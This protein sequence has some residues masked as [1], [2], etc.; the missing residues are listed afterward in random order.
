M[1]EFNRARYRNHGSKSLPGEHTSSTGSVLNVQDGIYRAGEFCQDVIGDHFA[2]YIGFGTKVEKDHDFDH[3]FRSWRYVSGVDDVGV[4][5]DEF[6]LGSIDVYEDAETQSGDSLIGWRPFPLDLYTRLEGGLPS[7]LPPAL[8]HLPSPSFPTNV[9]AYLLARTNPGKPAVDVPAFVGELRDVP[10]MFKIIGDNLVKSSGN[11]Y[12][13][14]NFGWRPMVSD[15]RKMVW[16]TEAVNKRLVVLRNL[17]AHGIHRPLRIGVESNFGEDNV[18]LPFT[19]EPPFDAAVDWKVHKWSTAELWGGTRWQMPE[20]AKLLL[21]SDE[22]LQKSKA[23][24]SVFGLGAHPAA[25]WELIPWSWLVDWFSHIQDILEVMYYRP[26]PVDFGGGYVCLKRRTIG[27]VFYDYDGD[28]LPFGR[29]GFGYDRITKQRLVFADAINTI[30]VPGTGFA[31]SG[32]QLSILAALVATRR[33]LG[34][35]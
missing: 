25:L 34:S 12:L 30:S 6:S 35:F 8:D 21:R 3:D 23:F 1:P 17:L 5:S 24:R 26:I 2:D 4:N 13:A 29:V 28:Y 14:Y 11:A 32:Y 10:R 19:E 16:V 27:K 18:S 9:V 31:F 15:M 20:S 22:D 33:R 7:V